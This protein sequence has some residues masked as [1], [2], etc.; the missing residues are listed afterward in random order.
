MEQMIAL[1]ITA[2]TRLTYAAAPAFVGRGTGTGYFSEVLRGDLHELS[3]QGHGSSFL[4]VRAGFHDAGASAGTGTTSTQAT[5]P[6]PDNEFYSLR[7]PAAAGDSQAQFA[8]AN[9]YFRGLGVPQDYGLA[10]IWYRKSAG[11]GY[12]PAQNQLGYMHQHKF[13]LPR[14]YKRALNYYRLAANQG[15]ALAEYNLAAMFQSGLYQLSG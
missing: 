11:Q 13:G 2:L 8:L 3:D 7:E 4:R 12:A 1:N 10:L 14:D 5:A 6:P 9:H 15:Y